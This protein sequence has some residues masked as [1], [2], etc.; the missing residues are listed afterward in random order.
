LIAEGLSNQE[1]ADRLV[2]G[3]GTVKSHVH[4]ILQ[5]LNVN[6]REDAAAYLAFMD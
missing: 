1:I 3:V 4:S 6:R 2:I 5:K